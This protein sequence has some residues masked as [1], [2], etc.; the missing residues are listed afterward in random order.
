[1]VK[2]KISDLLGRYKMTQ[3]ELAQKTGIRPATI[4]AL[5]H[6]ET[7][8]IE[9]EHIDKLCSALNCQPGDLLEYIPNQKR[10]Y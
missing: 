9:I 1:M 5:Y 10:S 7:K 4:S 2:I 3:K 8:R 6:E